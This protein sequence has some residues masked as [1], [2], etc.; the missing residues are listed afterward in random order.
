MTSVQGMRTTMLTVCIGA[1]A[2]PSEFVL[3]DSALRD[4]EDA[5]DRARGE[6]SGPTGSSVEGLEEF[7]RGAGGR[8]RAGRQSP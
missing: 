3:G 6:R 2:R 1:R 8:A 5:A 4:S 7:G